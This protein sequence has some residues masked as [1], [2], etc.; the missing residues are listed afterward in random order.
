MAKPQDVTDADFEQEVLQADLPVM[1][2]FW[3]E[4][5]GPCKMVSP[6]VEELA[7]EYDGRVKFA[8][9]DTEENVDTPARLGVRGL[10]TLMVFKGGQHGVG[11]APPPL[12]LVV[13]AVADFVQGLPDP[14]DAD[15][16]LVELQMDLLRFRVDPGG[17]P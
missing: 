1:V 7:E 12:R 13:W 9:L 17:L 5:C 8:K 15:P 6:L 2:D 10:P 16:R 11:E 4:W 14:V 3:A